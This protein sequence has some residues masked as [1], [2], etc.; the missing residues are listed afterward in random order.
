[1]RMNR[2]RRSLERR[3]PSL[4]DEFKNLYSVELDEMNNTDFEPAE[5]ARRIDED[6]AEDLFVL[7]VRNEDDY[8]E[9]Q[10]DGSGSVETLFFRIQIS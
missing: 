5:V 7:D 3:D 1:M 6:D 2:R 8:E 4:T 9:W 10:I